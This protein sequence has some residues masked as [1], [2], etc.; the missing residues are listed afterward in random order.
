MTP[1]YWF[2]TFWILIPSKV[3]AIVRR[4]HTTL[5]IFNIFAQAMILC[6]SLYSHR[7]YVWDLKADDTRSTKIGR[8]CRPTKSR[9]TKIGRLLLSHDRFCRQF[10][11]AVHINKMAHSSD[12]EAFTQSTRH[13]RANNKAISHNPMNLY[14]WYFYTTRKGNN[15][16]FLTPK[17]S[18][19]FQLGHRRR[20]RQREVG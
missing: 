5:D 10:S 19:K 12:D 2:A 18:A 11:S 13:K 3:C 8:Y 16:S 15:S 1:G 17:I 6:E 7:M 9:P 4:V 20:G 14:R